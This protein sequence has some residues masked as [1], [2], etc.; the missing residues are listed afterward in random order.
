MCELLVDLLDVDIRSVEG[1]H[2]GP[3]TIHFECRREVVGCPECGVVARVKD[4]HAVT[5][6]DLP[7][8][9]RPTRVVWHKR[10]FFCPDPEC[11]MGSWS[12]VDTRIAFPRHL[13][14][15]RAGRWLTWQIG[16]K[17]RNVQEI[18]DGLG[19]DWHTV[20]DALLRYGEALVDDENRVGPVEALG[21]D[22]TLFVREGEYRRPR[23]ATSIVDVGSGQLHDVVP[24]RDSEA[25]TAWIQ[26]R[27]VI[28]DLTSTTLPSTS[29]VPTPRSFPRRCRGRPRSPTR[30][31]WSR[32]ATRRCVTGGG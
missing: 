14:T 1:E 27:T 29:P 18:A 6:V 13:V 30:S 15:D 26:N 22:E 7:I 19:C 10:R 3:L 21:L 5:L 32:C 24:G 25:P 11:P 12:E 23:F 8:N 4:R 2:R 28:G 17:G 16:Q 9:A 31:M 20:N